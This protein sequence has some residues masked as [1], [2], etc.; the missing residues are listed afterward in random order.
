MRRMNEGG[1]AGMYFGGRPGELNPFLDFS[2]NFIPKVKPRP[3]SSSIYVDK[4]TVI[5]EQENGMNG[6]IY[7][8]G[9]L[10]DEFKE[11]VASTATDTSDQ[12]NVVDWFVMHRE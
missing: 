3:P 8:D 6:Y 4:G 7:I 2:G 12:K 9:T 11:N 5:N 10:K 1:L